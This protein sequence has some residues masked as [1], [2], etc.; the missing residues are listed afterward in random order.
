MAALSAL[1]TPAVTEFLPEP[2][3]FAGGPNEIESWVSARNEESD[4]FS[5]RDRTTQAFL[6]LLIL[7]PSRDA[8]GALTVRLG[9]LLAEKAWGQGYATELVKGLVG[10]C[11]K[12]AVPV[13]L[14]GG[15]EAGN[16]ASAAVLIKA[17]FTRAA[18]MST[19][20]TDT[21]RLIL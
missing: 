1:L 5:V 4:V 6:G 17:G 19:G 15:V 8:T 14:L 12:Q 9:F 21:F 18:D 13:Q 7:G 10:W 3:R 16:A 11:E 2:M 20:E